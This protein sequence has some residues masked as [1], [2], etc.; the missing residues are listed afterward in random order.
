[1]KRLLCQAGLN[2]KRYKSSQNG[3]Q[4]KNKTPKSRNTDINFEKQ[5]D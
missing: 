2:F 1:M 3:T 5:K 4:W